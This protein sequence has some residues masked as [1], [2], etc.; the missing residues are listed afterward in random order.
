MLKND[1]I[2]IIMLNFTP[3]NNLSPETTGDFI[4]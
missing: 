2:P 4:L 3:R 1:D